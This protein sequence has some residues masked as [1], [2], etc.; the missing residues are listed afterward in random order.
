MWGKKLKKRKAVD[1]W[2][3][4]AMLVDPKKVKITMVWAEEPETAEAAVESSA[5]EEA[6]AKVS[7]E[8]SVIVENLES[9]EKNLEQ[10]EPNVETLELGVN[11]HPDAG[12]CV[13]SHEAAWSNLE[14][15]DSNVAD[16]ENNVGSVEGLCSALPNLGDVE[17]GFEVTDLTVSETPSS[18]ESAE[19]LKP[20]D[21]SAQN[22]ALDEGEPEKVIGTPKDLPV[23][24]EV[25]GASCTVDSIESRKAIEPVEVE[26][27]VELEAADIAATDDC[28]HDVV[29]EGKDPV[30]VQF[31]KALERTR[32][33]W[34]SDDQFVKIVQKLQKGKNLKRKEFEKVYLHIHTY[35]RYH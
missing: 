30:N 35:C 3:S 20:L 2:H 24:T 11:E 4:K 6:L 10:S 31:L 8:K 15:M 33:M 13:Q 1:R 19:N 17:C 34:D 28:V 12:V 9:E 18:V 26:A 32:S 14:T 7:G 16:V 23:E 25:P 5:I 27:P 29:S 22:V 21:T